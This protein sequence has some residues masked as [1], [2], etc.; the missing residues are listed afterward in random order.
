M[1][2]PQRSERAQRPRRHGQPTEVATLVHLL[3][4]RYR[5]E[6]DRAER[7]AAELRDIRHSRLWPFFAWLRR[8]RARFQPSLQPPPVPEE[9]FGPFPEA[10][11]A[12]PRPDLPCSIVIPI[13]DQ[14][15][16]LRTCLRSLRRTTLVEQ[17]EIILVDNGSICRDTLRF[18]ARWRERGR[19]LVLSRPGPFNFSWLCNEGARIA[20][21]EVLLFLNNDVTALKPGW[22]AAMAGLAT[23]PTVGAV[24]ATLL[25]PNGTLQHAGLA[26]DHSGRWHHP[27]R[28]ALTSGAGTASILRQV[29]TAAAATGACLMVEKRRFAEVGGF[30][31]QLPVTGNDADLCLR[32]A[33]KGLAT[34]VTPAARLVHFESL[35]RGFTCEAAA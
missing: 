24:G 35:T 21:G 8:L 27:F 25:Y 33:A 29:H 4:E 18:L 30:D 11:T 20:T 16:L 23:L 34:V 22:L 14:A 19:G 5:Q 3:N 28:F 6:F 10:G 7:L 17:P 26:R 31:E 13:R 15:A 12:P 1:P 9:P 2:F 32:L